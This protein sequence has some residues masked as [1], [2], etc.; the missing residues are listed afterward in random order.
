MRGLYGL[1]WRGLRAR[2][3]R[4]TLTIVGVALGVAVL[5]AG[6]AT[7]AG[8][9]A[10]IRRAVDGLVGRADLRVAAFDETGLS[11]TA[12]GVI[13][14]TPGVAVAAPSFERTTYLGTGEF[15]PGPLPAPVT[16]AGIDPAREPRIHDLSLTDGAAL[17]SAGDPAALVSPTLARQ[18]GL[19]IGSRLGI[20]GIDEPVYLQVSG[21]LVGDGPWAGLTG[22]V[23]VT[24]LPIARSVFGADGVTR[25]DL[26]LAERADPQAVIDSLETRLTSEPFVV[27]TPDD[28]AASMQAST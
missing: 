3:L 6:L 21:I 17:T 9:D 12:V 18:D 14:Q 28:I 5:Y 27:S 16:L 11:D 22:R 20:Q 1:A 25:V 10:A 26:T 7:D 13:E 4:T 8:V 19:T 24:T 2:P 23:V 15:G